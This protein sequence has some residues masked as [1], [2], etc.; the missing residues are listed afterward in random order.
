MTI[1]PVTAYV[2]DTITS[3]RESD[4]LYALKG[5]YTISK[6]KTVKTSD[7]RYELKVAKVGNDF[8]TWVLFESK[9]VAAIIFEARIVPKLRNT[10]EPHASVAKKFRGLGLTT[11]VYTWFLQTG[12][13]LVTITHTADA[14]KVWD[15]LSKR[16]K[17]AYLNHRTQKLSSSPNDAYRVLFGKR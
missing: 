9:P 15:K 12:A 3:I 10:Y 5:Y 13:N 16:F 4:V 11:M 14:R 17:T 2:I 8:K 6:F 1:R 7:T